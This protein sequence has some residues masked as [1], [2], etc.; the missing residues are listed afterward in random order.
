MTDSSS[1]EDGIGE[2][3]FRD[4]SEDTLLLESVILDDLFTGEKK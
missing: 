3:L 4:I 2:F 1:D